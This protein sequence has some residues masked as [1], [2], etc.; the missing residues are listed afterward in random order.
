MRRVAAA[1]APPLTC[2][3][4]SVRCGAGG[5][6]WSFKVDAFGRVVKPGSAVGDC[7]VESA[8]PSPCIV[9][10]GSVVRARPRPSDADVIDSGSGW[11]TVRFSDG[12]AFVYE[13]RVFNI[14]TGL[15]VD[16]LRRGEPPPAHVLLAGFP[17]TGKT[18]L[19]HVVAR[20]SGAFEVSLNA[21]DIMSKWVGDSAKRMRRAIEEARRRE[22]AVVGIHDFDSLVVSGRGDDV[23]GGGAPYVET[24]NVLINGMDAVRGEALL[25]IITTNRSINTVDAALRRR[26]VPII[27][28]PPTPSAVDAWVRESRAGPVTAAVRKWGVEEVGGRL[29]GLVSGGATWGMLETGLRISL[30]TGDL[31]DLTQPDL[32]GLG[33]S[34]LSPRQPPPQMD[35]PVKEE[36]LRWLPVTRP[37]R[38]VPSLGNP[39]SP[40]NDSLAATAAL[41]AGIAGGRH[42]IQVTRAEFAADAAAVAVQVGAILLL[43]AALPP[44]TRAAILS[45]PAPIIMSRAVD[46]DTRSVVAP[47]ELSDAASAYL[48]R[49]A[50]AMHGSPCMDVGRL[51]VSRSKLP[52]FIHALWSRGVDCLTALNTA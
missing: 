49:L 9:V 42:V 39:G 41:A 47:A 46:D 45:T 5:G 32:S 22:P 43:P 36:L 3:S 31:G 35:E 16:R 37:I 48:A 38:V 4:V 50:V 24:R 28:P 40:V 2:R 44:T 25:F 7:V 23:E 29:R 17:G 6:A 15:A 26:T 51:R 18:E 10:A 34:F 11:V 13:K 8:E 30:A 52:G 1:P 33:Y 20:M 12:R 21:A 14:V 27:M 19:V